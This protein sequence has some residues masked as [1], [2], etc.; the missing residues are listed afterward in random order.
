MHLH[1]TQSNKVP[2]AANGSIASWVPH[3]RLKR[4]AAQAGPVSSVIKMPTNISGIRNIR[5]KSEGLLR[6]ILRTKRRVRPSQS[7]IQI[8]KANNPTNNSKG[9]PATKPTE[10]LLFHNLAKDNSIFFL[11]FAGK[12]IHLSLDAPFAVMARSRTHFHPTAPKGM[13]RRACH[14]V[15]FCNTPPPQ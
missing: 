2:I 7:I 11:S 12:G 13:D 1:T 3:V 9:S 5:I 14:H 8:S 4:N 10:R 6:I 15:K